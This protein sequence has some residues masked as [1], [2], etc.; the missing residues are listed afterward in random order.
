MNTSQKIRLLKSLCSD[1]VL[2]AELF[3]VPKFVHERGVLCA[4]LFSTAKFVYERGVSCA[5]L[6][7]RCDDKYLLAIV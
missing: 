5:E 3:P 4:E 6:F 7:H 1:S 2:C